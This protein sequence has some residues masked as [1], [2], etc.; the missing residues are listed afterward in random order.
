M[1]PISFEAYCSWNR[2][3]DYLSRPFSLTRSSPP[4]PLRCALSPR[5]IIDMV[6]TVA[7]TITHLRFP[8]KVHRWSM[9][10]CPRP[11]LMRPRISLTHHSL[12]IIPWQSEWR[13]EARR[14]QG[15][16][17][18]K[19]RNERGSRR[20][21]I[22]VSHTGRV[23]LVSLVVVVVT[24]QVSPRRAKVSTM[25][26]RRRT[27]MSR[28][29]LPSSPRPPCLETSPLRRSHRSTVSDHRSPPHTL[30][31]PLVPNAGRSDR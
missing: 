3:A 17:G 6:I 22:R 18:L 8:R 28:R 31:R 14:E 7:S 2:V 15:V 30:V 13:T 11:W 10:L 24:L 20:L 12:W 16:V 23:T 5:T 21:W 9:R 19:V 4:L 1:P 27:I 25:H 26:P 29:R